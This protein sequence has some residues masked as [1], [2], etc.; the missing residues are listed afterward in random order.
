MYPDQKYY[1]HDINFLSDVT[2]GP[3][4]PNTMM[5][6]KMASASANLAVGDKLV[7][8]ATVAFA[9]L[10]DQGLIKTIH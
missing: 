10:P 8:S 7:L 2:P 3:M 6:A 5:M 1:M 4:P 9:A